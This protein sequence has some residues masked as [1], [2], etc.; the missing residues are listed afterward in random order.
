MIV[1][2]H[3]QGNALKYVSRILATE[4]HFIRTVKGFTRLYRI[5]NRKIRVNL[6]VFNVLRN[7]LFIVSG[8]DLNRFIV[9]RIVSKSVSLFLFVFMIQSAKMSL[10]EIR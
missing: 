4:M 8:L 5:S 1:L 6:N 9:C 10:P 7:Y 3:L 2:V